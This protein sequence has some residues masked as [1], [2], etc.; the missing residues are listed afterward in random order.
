MIRTGAR[1]TIGRSCSR[2]SCSPTPKGV[3]RSREIAQLCQDN[4]VFMALSAD[5]TPHF[6]TIADFLSRQQA[7]IISI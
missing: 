7:Q 6:T 1:P 2:S 4:V 3:T 5:A